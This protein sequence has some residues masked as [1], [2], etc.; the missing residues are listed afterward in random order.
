MADEIDK[1]GSVDYLD[2]Y[3]CYD[4][5]GMIFYIVKMMAVIHEVLDYGIV[6]YKDKNQYSLREYGF[7]VFCAECGSFRELQFYEKDNLVCEFS[8]LEYADR[9]E[10]EYCLAQ[11]NQKKEYTPRYKT[12]ETDLLL[13][14]IK[15]YEKEKCKK[16][17]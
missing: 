2:N 17:I 11:Y 15:E 10:I 6:G 3:R 5:G 7:N 13:E 12:R 8:D 4:C 9:E 1:Y 14:K 16:K